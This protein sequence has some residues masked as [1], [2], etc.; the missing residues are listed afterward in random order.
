MLLAVLANAHPGVGRVSTNHEDCS[1]LAALDQHRSRLTLHGLERAGNTPLPM[2][3]PQGNA[4]H[5]HIHLGSVLRAEADGQ[6]LDEAHP[7][8]A[9]NCFADRGTRD[10]CGHVVIDQTGH[11]ITGVVR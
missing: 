4:E 8:G 11:H 5:R 10:E 1:P 6:H 3:S 2:Q 9:M 7:G